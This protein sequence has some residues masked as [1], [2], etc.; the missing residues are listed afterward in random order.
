MTIESGQPP[1]NSRPR[2]W[3]GGLSTLPG[4]VLGA[5]LGWYGGFNILIWTAPKD[6]NWDHAIGLGF[7]FFVLG[8]VGAVVTACIGA[9]ISYLVFAAFYKRQ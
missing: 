7:F 4:I 1:Q 8:G 3:M 9:V 5:C 2:F 6:T